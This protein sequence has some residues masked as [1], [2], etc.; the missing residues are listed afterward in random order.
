[1]RKIV[2]AVVLA[3]CVLVSVVNAEYVP[4]TVE[5]NGLERLIAGMLLPKESSFANY[6]IL[7]DLKNELAFTE[8]E[9]K[10]VDIQP[11]NGGVTGKWDLIKKEITFG[12]TSEKWVVD[13]LKDLDRKEKLLPEHIS[14][15][16]K[17]IVKE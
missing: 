4:K 7:N 16:E 12:E 6:K 13:A 2:L 15:Y 1:M 11:A 17:F 10:L 14:L 9:Q 8:E 3:L 5:L